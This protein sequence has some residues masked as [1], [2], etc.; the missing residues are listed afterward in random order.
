MLEIILSEYLKFYNGHDSPNNNILYSKLESKII[1][2]EEEI[3]T[4]S[5][6]YILGYMLLCYIKCIICNFFILHFIGA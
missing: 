5:I 2:E 3:F 4:I 6:D 1:S